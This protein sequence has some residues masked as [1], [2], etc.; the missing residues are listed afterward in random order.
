M[1]SVAADQTKEAPKKMGRF[2]SSST[3]S[4]KQLARQSLGLSAAQTSKEQPPNEPS[5][6]DSSLDDEKKSKHD[7]TGS[8]SGIIKQARKQ[9]SSSGPSED[10]QDTKASELPPLPK[11]A[12]QVSTSWWISKTLHDSLLQQGNLKGDDVSATAD[13]KQD[14]KR[15]KSLNDELR[16]Y[17]PMLGDA[18]NVIARKYQKDITGYCL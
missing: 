2:R 17:F 14:L 9:V 8:L 5:I 16:K 3:A 15:Q 7:R 4:I 13:D 11:P 1:L 18:E 6:G 10:H 12:K